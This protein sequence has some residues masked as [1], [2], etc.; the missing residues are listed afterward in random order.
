[1]SALARYFNRQG[2]QVAGYDKTPSD[3]TS[4]LEQ[5]GIN[6]HYTDLGEDI[7]MAFKA[8]E[9]TLVVYTP[10]IPRDD[11]EVKYFIFLSVRKF[12]DC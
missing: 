1:M 7:P 3:L 6:V 11:G 9:N 5:E 10:A 8:K 12:W 4:L 2:W